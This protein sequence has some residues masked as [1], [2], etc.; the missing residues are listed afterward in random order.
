VK[1]FFN[2]DTPDTREPDVELPLPIN[3]QARIKIAGSEIVT[4][5]AI[6]LTPAPSKTF[7]TDKFAFPVTIVNTF[8]LIKHPY[9]GVEPPT[10]NE[11]ICIRD[12]GGIVAPVKLSIK[13]LFALSLNEL[14]LLVRTKEFNRLLFLIVIS[15]TLVSSR[16]EK[17]P[18]ID[19]IGEYDTELPIIF[20]W[21]QV[22]K[23]RLIELLAKL[24][25]LMTT[26]VESTTSNAWPTLLIAQL[27]ILIF[28]EF[29]IKIPMFKGPA[30]IVVDFINALEIVTLEESVIFI[31]DTFAG[32]DR[33]NPWKSI[34][35]P[36]EVTSIADV[37][38]EY[39]A[40]EQRT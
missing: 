19:P 29:S 17:V 23:T 10:I 22:L 7:I 31:P 20:T 8:N 34:V 9:V 11:P 15:L 13:K 6:I 26:E 30:A 37:D 14:Q 5:F 40:L 36:L 2:I 39:V 28:R 4:T 35:T 33:V 27:N 25:S 38:P 16:D 24:L 32:K 21:L 12:V 1:L 18:A 3:M